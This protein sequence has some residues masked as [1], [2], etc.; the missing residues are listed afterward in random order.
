MSDIE[1]V[2]KEGKHDTDDQ[3]IGEDNVF[4]S[5]HEER[6]HMGALDSDGEEDFQL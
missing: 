4:S 1:N 3:L 5:F 2:C 6:F